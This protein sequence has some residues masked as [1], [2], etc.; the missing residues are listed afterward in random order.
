MYQ[1]LNCNMKK[2]INCNIEKPLDE[3]IKRKNSK[4]GYRHRCIECYKQY[5]KKYRDNK[6]DN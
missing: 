6:K 1:K 4:D 2:C 5:Q 3:F